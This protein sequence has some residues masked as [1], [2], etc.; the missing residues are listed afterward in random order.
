MYELSQLTPLYN[1][2]VARLSGMTQNLDN[3]MNT[4]RNEKAITEHKLTR[5]RI[6]HIITAL[7]REREDHRAAHQF[8]KKRITREKAHWFYEGG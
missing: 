8:M 1:E 3:K 7:E 2:E 4:A 6:S 5:H